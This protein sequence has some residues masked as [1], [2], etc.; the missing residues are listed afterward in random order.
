MPAPD[1]PLFAD[2][3]ASPLLATLLVVGIALA[4]FVGLGNVPLFVAA[5]KDVPAQ[6]HRGI[7]ARELLMS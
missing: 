7:I 2:L 6:R 5:L 4:F 3:R 1:R